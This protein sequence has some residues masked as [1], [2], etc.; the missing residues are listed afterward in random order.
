[1]R[2]VTLFALLKRRF[3][4]IGEKGLYSFIMCGEVWINGERVRDPLRKCK[5]SELVEIRTKTSFVSRGG[6]KLVGALA[7]FGTDCAGKIFLDCGASSGGFTDCLLRCG[8]IRVYA[9][10]VGYS[11]FD[12]RLRRDP[13]V[14]LM[15][16]TNIMDVTESDLPDPPQAA[17]IDLS[18]RSLRGA[19]RHVLDL[20]SEKWAIA[21]VKPQFEWLDPPADYDGIV[22]EDDLRLEILLRLAADLEAEQVYLENTIVSPLHGAKGNAEYFFLLTRRECGEDGEVKKKITSLF[23]R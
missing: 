22:R 21:L 20:T 1:M 8:A 13:R 23:G 5:G 11:Q 6:E 16:R 10:D 3:P 15:E 12:F 2:T 4:S 17:V 18:F 19:A 9:V 14:S 7:A